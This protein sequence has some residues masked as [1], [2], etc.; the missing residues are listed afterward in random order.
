MSK[1]S[2]INL[3]RISIQV[4]SREAE[5]LADRALGLESE[6]LIQKPGLSWAGHLCDLGASPFPPLGFLLIHKMRGSPETKQGWSL[7]GSFPRVLDPH[8]AACIEGG[9]V[10]GSS[11][12]DQFQR[13]HLPSMVVV[14]AL[15]PLVLKLLS[16]KPHLAGNQYRKPQVN[17]T[18][19]SAIPER[20]PLERKKTFNKHLP[21]HPLIVSNTLRAT[22]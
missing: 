12:L 15:L 21:E 8:A 19:E 3:C 16:P 9:G 1:G 4:L 10:A 20:F 17:C 13:L 6:G 7:A 22:S 2:P 18:Q 14:S 11:A 5:G